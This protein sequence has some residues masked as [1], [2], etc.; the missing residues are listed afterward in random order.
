[1]VSAVV[2]GGIPVARDAYEKITVAANAQVML[3]TAVTALRNEL[4][5]A[6]IDNENE[7]K[8][9]DGNLYYF[10]PTIQSN[11]LISLGQPVGYEH[12]TFMVTP[13]V[14]SKGAIA[15]PL[16]SKAAGNKDL[17]VVGTIELGPQKGIV[18]VKNLQV[19]DKDDNVYAELGG[20]DSNASASEIK[21]RLISASMDGKCM[22]GH[23]DEKIND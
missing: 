12:K 3:S 20:S 17:F 22:P 14:G 7:K 16:V 2:A 9:K 23:E 4:C 6:V 21:I 11:S 1:M 13:Y 5:T 8:S 19:L 18:T 15:R 10:S